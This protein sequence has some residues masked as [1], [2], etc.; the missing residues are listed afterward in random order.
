MQSDCLVQCYNEFMKEKFNLIKLADTFLYRK[1]LISAFDRISIN[2]G[3]NCDIPLDSNI[4][5]NEKCKP[6]CSSKQ[7]ITE[8][9]PYPNLYKSIYHVYD[10]ELEHSLIPDVIVRHSLE[11]TL[12]SFVCNFGGLLGM[13]LGFSI[14]SISK[15]ILKSIQR[16]LVF[17]RKKINIIKNNINNNLN[18]INVIVN[19]NTSSNQNNFPNVEIE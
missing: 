6:D 9:K 7:H 18:V 15:H 8:I 1:E 11:M 12:M 14:L 5:C 3:E 17:D 4:K 2:Y 16:F 13:W 19:S 10:I